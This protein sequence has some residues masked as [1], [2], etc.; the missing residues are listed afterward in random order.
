MAALIVISL[1]GCA[2]S[3]E[4]GPGFDLHQ[5]GG[6]AAEADE[7]ASGAV[8]VRAAF[9]EFLDSQFA[10]FVTEDTL[11]LHYTLRYPEN[12]GIERPEP[13]LGEWGTEYFATI[14]EQ[15]RQDMVTLKS[16]PRADLGDEQQLIY[17]ILEYYLELDIGFFDEGLTYYMS[18][19]KPYSGMQAELPIL[20]AEYKFYDESDVLDYLALLKDVDRFF[21]SALSFEE[22]K[23]EMGLGKADIALEAIIESCNDFTALRTNNFLIEIFGEKIEELGL[24]A[25]KAEKYAEE[26]KDSVLNDVIPAYDSLVAGLKALKGKGKN[27]SGLCHFDKGKEYYEYMV[28]SSVGTTES[29]ESLAEKIDGRL[30]MVSYA[31]SYLINENEG[32]YEKML[33]PDFGATDPEEIIDMLKYGMMGFF[34]ENA[35]ATHT[36]KSLHPSLAS[37]F[38]AA[39]YLS[40]PIDD[41]S[42]A[43]IY[44]NKGSMSED[45]LFPVLA[46][47]GYPGHLYQD[48]YFKSTGMHP[49]REALSS[50][51]YI[52]GW[53]TYA[54]INSYMFAE[55]PDMGREVAMLLGFNTEYR[56]AIQSR[57]D[58]GVNYEGWTYDELKEY[59]KG[60]GIDSSASWRS[61]YEYVIKDPAKILRYYL[62]YLEFETL[63]DNAYKQMGD[64]FSLIDFHKCILDVGPVPF[65][66]VEEAVA[67]LIS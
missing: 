44:I 29:L 38:P 54:E 17:D 59:L 58:I 48:T 35:G 61:I 40:V 41:Y 11:T 1:C 53:A 37:S 9:D 47:E 49:M 8:A 50:I 10:D 20:L 34:P 2:G 66:I 13:T 51:G 14:E 23:A 64:G 57:C 45:D 3:G 56:L 32:V 52:E 46:H 18:L 65:F 25:E 12:F 19:L 31:T 62:G 22:E 60:Y 16:F 21:K 30:D 39:F 42:S 15:T 5:V 6:G 26:N 24:P 43:V 28:K 63:Y 7:N 33:K 55:F 67:R 4:E 27:D 36:L